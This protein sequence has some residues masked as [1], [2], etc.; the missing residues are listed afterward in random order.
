MYQLQRMYYHLQY[1]KKK[2]YIPTE[3]CLTCK[4]MEGK[5]INTAIQEDSHQFLNKLVQN[6]ENTFTKDEKLADLQRILCAK[7]L[8]ELQC[9][10]C[11][12]KIQ[13]V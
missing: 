9:A 7:T 1:S 6:A 4:D 11:L 5:P 13:K 2:Y 10:H 8:T 12:N 3:F